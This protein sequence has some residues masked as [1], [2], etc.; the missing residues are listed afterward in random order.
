M[1]KT[2]NCGR[3]LSLDW[4]NT[5][6]SSDGK[7]KCKYCSSILSPKIERIRKHLETCKKY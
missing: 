5:I 2:D 7:I 3:K 1:P 6:K 4:S